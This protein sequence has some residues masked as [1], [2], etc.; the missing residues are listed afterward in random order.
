MSLLNYYIAFITPF[1]IVILLGLLGF[2]YSFVI[3]MFIYYVYRCFL[4][5]YRLNQKEI[6]NKKEIFGSLLYQYG[7]SFILMS[8][9][10]K[11]K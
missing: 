8:Y 10:L 11:N 7:H 6:V 5:Y 9:I 1:L 2:S 3:G 4:D